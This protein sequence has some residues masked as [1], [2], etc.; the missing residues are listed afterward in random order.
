MGGKFAEVILS[1]NKFKNHQVLQKQK[2]EKK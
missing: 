2:K 1:E